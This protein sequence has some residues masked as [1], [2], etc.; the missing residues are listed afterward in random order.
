[1]TLPERAEHI[2]RDVFEAAG[3]EAVSRHNE[4]LRLGGG[5]GRRTLPERR[6]WAEAW[7][8]LARAGLVCPEPNSD[9]DMWFLTGPGRQA[10][11]GGDITGSLLLSGVRP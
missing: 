6:R 7:L 3:E 10:L 9:R 1:M 5:P 11:S 2:L 8:L 4:I